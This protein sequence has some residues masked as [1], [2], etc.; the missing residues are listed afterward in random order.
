MATTPSPTTFSIPDLRAAVRGRVIA[1][2]D[3]GYDEARTVF[4]GGI[5]RRPAVIV[6]VADATRRRDGHRARAG[7]WSRRSRSAAVATA[8]S[9]IAW[10]RA[11]SSS[12][13]PT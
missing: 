4:I 9:A 5:D 13:S 1:P 3:P 11:G 2:D 10:P 8:A 12:T 7:D 6:R